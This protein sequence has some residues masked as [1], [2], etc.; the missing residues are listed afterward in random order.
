[1]GMPWYDIRAFTALKMPM[2]DKWQ[3]NRDITSDQLCAMGRVA[4]VALA[5]VKRERHEPRGHV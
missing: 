2:A 1:M 3:S 5:T 4:H